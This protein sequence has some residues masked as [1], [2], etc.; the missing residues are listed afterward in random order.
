MI[1]HTS[2]CKKYQR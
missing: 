1:I 2:F